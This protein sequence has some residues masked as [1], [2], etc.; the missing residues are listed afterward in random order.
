VGGCGPDGR[1]EQL[2]CGMILS[3]TELNP[4]DTCYLAQ[5]MLHW[6]DFFFFLNQRRWIF[7]LSCVASTVTGFLHGFLAQPS[8]MS[9]AKSNMLCTPTLIFLYKDKTEFN[10]G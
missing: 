8:M 9:M 2:T 5:A 1:P 7:G 4:K 10:F 3:N 6:N